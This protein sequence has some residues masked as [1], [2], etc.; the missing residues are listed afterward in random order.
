MAPP[1]PGRLDHPRRA[2]SGLNAHRRL[3]FRAVV[4]N[5]AWAQCTYS[6]ATSESP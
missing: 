5:A 3:S 2:T 4:A 1:I 6:Y